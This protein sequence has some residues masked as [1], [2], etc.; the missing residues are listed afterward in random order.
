MI[1]TATLLA[2]GALLAG[3]ASLSSPPAPA[4]KTLLLL[5]E[6]HDNA[7]GH[8]LRLAELEARVAAG[9]QPA[10]AMEQF[11]REHQAALTQ[12]QADCGDN[13]RCVIDAARGSARWQWEFYEPVIA[14]AQRHRLPLLAANLSRAEASRVV[15][16]SFAAALSPEL[17]AR[18]ALDALPPGLF[19]GQIAAVREGHC[20]QLP[21]NLLPGM[22]RA[23]IARD[24]VMAEVMIAA[25]RDAV[26]LA[27]NGHVRD[28][29]GAPYWLRKLGQES[30]S[31]AYAESAAPAGQYGRSV[32][33]TPAERQD[34]CRF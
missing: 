26:L 34:P 3:C 27:G 12:A 9:W 28:D 22:A 8:R 25:G 2:L 7:E 23:Q 30:E 17:Q 11:D 14:L 21:E 1:R 6:T 5:G 16:E 33:I 20:N 15:K 31:I 4:G 18:Y 24:V 13:A 29:L 10:I 19:A 32:V